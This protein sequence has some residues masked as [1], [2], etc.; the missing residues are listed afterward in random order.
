MGI[1]K[2]MREKGSMKDMWEKGG[3]E[4]YGDKGVEIDG[5]DEEYLGEG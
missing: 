2:K 4:E 1:M 3:Y 5:E